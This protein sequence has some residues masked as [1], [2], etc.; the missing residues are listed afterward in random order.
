ML[1]S[2]SGG[3]VRIQSGGDA[4]IITGIIT[5]CGTVRCQDGVEMLTVR[6]ESKLMAG[7]AKLRN[8]Q[9]H[10]VDQTD[11]VEVFFL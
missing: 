3:Y 9:G 4:S 5:W 2:L 1:Q 10:K 8:L 6:R 11:D 7:E